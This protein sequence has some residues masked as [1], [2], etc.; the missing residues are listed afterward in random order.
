MEFSQNEEFVADYLALRAANDQLRERGKQWL[1]ETLSKFCA[2]INR[3]F[4]AASAQPALQ[5]GRQ[6]WQ[7]KVGNSLM[8]G[9][10]IGIRY[11]GRTLLVEA[12]WPREPQHGFVPDQG[13]ARGRVS[14]STSPILEARPID[15]LVLRHCGGGEAAW[16]VIGKEGL[17][18]MVTEA[19][20]R[21][22]L[23]AVLSS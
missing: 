3:N 23:E 15:E 12:G 17:G 9:E 7:F 21:A 19:R 1:M 20:L 16:Y 8:V 11:L 2:E 22:Y 13:L 4:S 5:I 14:L 18:Q 10:R 6:Q